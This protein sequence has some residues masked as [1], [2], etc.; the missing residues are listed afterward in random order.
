MS[1]VNLVISVVFTFTDSQ[2][3][4]WHLEEY[5]GR[6]FMKKGNEIPTKHKGQI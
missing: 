3:A 2:N 4:L 5:V 1:Y 6:F